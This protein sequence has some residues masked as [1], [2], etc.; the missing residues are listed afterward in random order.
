[1]NLLNEDIMLLSSLS[2]FVVVPWTNL[3]L[4][5]GSQDELLDSHGFRTTLCK[6]ASD[7]G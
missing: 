4:L 6:A 1:M 5:I 2:A 3:S 7:L